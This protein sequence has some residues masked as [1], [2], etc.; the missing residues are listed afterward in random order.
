MSIP[1]F[2]TLPPWAMVLGLAAHLGAG[3]G[4]GILYFRS[5]WWSACRLADRRS[6]VATIASM[7]GRFALIGGVLTLTSLEGALPLLTTALGVL[8]A[9]F[10]AMNRV[11]EAVQ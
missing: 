8:T 7:I 2:D 6:L 10:A 5:L 1:S 11:R 4:L 3:F 9:R